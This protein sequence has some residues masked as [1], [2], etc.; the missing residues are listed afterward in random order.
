ME[1]I[2]EGKIPDCIKA[3]LSKTGF[4]SK[5]AIVT[6]TDEKLN[7]IESFINS[8]SID[9]GSELSCCSAEQYQEQTEFMLLPGHRAAILEIVD[10]F[11]SK[12]MAKR[13]KKLAKTRVPLFETPTG[14]VD[15]N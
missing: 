5:L 6:L 11:N 13:S 2:A 8:K 15:D 12:Q 10:R 14:S 1:T 7:E 9:I 3:I 4:D